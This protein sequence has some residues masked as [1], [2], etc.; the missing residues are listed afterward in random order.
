MK[1]SDVVARLRAEKESLKGLGAVHVYLFGSVARNEARRG[2]DVGVF[3]DRDKRRPMGLPDLVLLRRRMQDV[4][5][6][7]VDLGTR[8]GLHPLIRRAVER[9]A[10]KVF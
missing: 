9:T 6:V 2:S 3:I 10:I 1:S 8:G 7:K 4:L 5:G